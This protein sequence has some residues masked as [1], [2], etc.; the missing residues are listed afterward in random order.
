M[1][2][3]SPLLTRGSPEN[4]YGEASQDPHDMGKAG[5]LEV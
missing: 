1:V 5:L 4:M 3:K 2:D